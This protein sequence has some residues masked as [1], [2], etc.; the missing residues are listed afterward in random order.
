MD[1]LSG[2]PADLTTSEEAF[3]AY[4]GPKLA[5]HQINPLGGAVMK[6]ADL[7]FSRSVTEQSIPSGHIGDLPVLFPSGDDLPLT[8]DGHFPF[9]L[10]SASFYLVSRYE[11]YLPFQSDRHGRFP[12]SASLSVRLGILDI[13]VINHWLA[14]FQEWLIRLYPGLRLQPPSYTYYPTIDIDHAYAYRYRPLWRTFGGV[15]RS[16]LKGKINDI[17]ARFQVLSGSLRDPYDTYQIIRNIHDS[18]GLKTRFFLLFA[19]YGGNDNNIPTGCAAMKRLIAELSSWSEIGIHP[20]LRSSH[21]PDLLINELD[22]LT[23]ITGKSVT[24]SRQHFLK[25]SMP[26][27]YRQLIRAG[28]TDDYTMGYA[29]KPGFRAGISNPFRFFDL[30]KDEATTLTIHP[31]VLM[32]V[33]FRDY[34]HLGVN[35]SLAEIKQIIDRVRSSRGELITLWHNESLS[36]YNR[37]KGW[38]QLYRSVVEYAAAQI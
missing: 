24:T 4:A 14:F 31:V 33:T 7:L 10:F 17:T 13:P 35:E 20:S 30:E 12:P 34:L 1:E 25:L 6:P 21:H 29:S 37:W 38:L 15:G 36:E 32:D 2:I 3:Q 22:G 11:E 23:K 5:Y 9:D 19:D 18:K 8:T 28:I 16:V 26:E 27:T